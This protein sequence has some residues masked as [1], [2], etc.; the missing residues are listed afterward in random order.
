MVIQ[1][2][3]FSEWRPIK[4]STTWNKILHD[5]VKET[6]MYVYMW[7]V[8]VSV[9]LIGWLAP[10]NKSL[11]KVLLL[12]WSPR[13][14]QQLRRSAYRKYNKLLKSTNLHQ[15]FHFRVITRRN[16]PHSFRLSGTYTFRG[17]II[18]FKSPR[19]AWKLSQFKVLFSL[20]VI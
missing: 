18:D 16:D 19:R 13:H 2:L 8:I 6:G 17:I 11:S 10:N 5:E 15:M 20:T 9:P 3:L 4:P 12:I 7:V 1:Q 14:S